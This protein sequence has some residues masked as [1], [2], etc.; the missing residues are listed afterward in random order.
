MNE[1]I[2]PFLAEA[3]EL[4]DA[5]SDDLLALESR[6]DD[7]R[8]LDNLFR[9]F[10]TLKGSAALL[11]FGPMTLAL[12]AA[13]DLLSAVR[14]QGG[15][16]AGPV[17]QSCL[18]TLDQV[19]AWVAAIEAVGELPPDAAG[20][21][22]E[23][24]ANLRRVLGGARR[25]TAA[26][27]EAAVP[28]WV[29]ELAGREAAATREAVQAGRSV[30]ALR[31]DPRPDC[32]LNG[33]DPLAIVGRVPGLLAVRVEPR[34]PWPAPAEIDPF[35]CNLTITALSDAPREEVAPVFRLVSDQVEISGLPPVE[36]AGA[37][38]IG[39]V[40]AAII[41]EQLA[42]L[43]VSHPAG[44]RAGVERSAIGCA[45]NVLAHAGRGEADRR[46]H[47]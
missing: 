47:V 3:R 41:A 24:A 42:L 7:P 10:H 9:G 19:A 1:L 29:R 30:T 37:P 14:D 40:G 31:Y 34:E 8:R 5:A 6:P 13:E 4:I 12:H 18:E 16:M 21:G 23:L 35:S 15:P 2:E 26:R 39:T 33:D 43:A 20:R 36:T 17:I 44:I 27:A 38:S 25:E 22:A 45:A 32:F 46:A 11:D 28:D